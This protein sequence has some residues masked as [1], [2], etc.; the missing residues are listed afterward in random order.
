MTQYDVSVVIPTY[1]RRPL[2]Q[3]AVE[4]VMAQTFSGRIELVVCDD[5]STDDTGSYV[6]ELDAGLDVRYLRN[7]AT[8]G[9]SA[10]RNRGI[11]ESSGS[12]VGLLD[13]DDTWCPTKLE[14]CLEIL[15]ES[16]VDAVVTGLHRVF[17]DGSKETVAI[18]KE[19]VRFP[20]LLAMPVVGGGSSLVV[21]RQLL[22]D[23]GLFDEALPR[24]QD[25]DLLVRLAQRTEI[26]IVPEPLVEKT[27]T[28]LASLQSA[29][30]ARSRFTA[31]HAE[32]IA[33]FSPRDR[34]RIL[35]NHDLHLFRL[36]LA[37]Q[38]YGRAA[39]HALAACRRYPRFALSV[40]KSL[41]IATT[42][43]SRLSTSNPSG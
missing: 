2:L 13:D 21:A 1:N 6:T 41:P 29:E 38:R 18:A 3:R 37:H 20:R 30:I 28:G 19:H 11:R 23:V 33:A 40:W 5:G 36:A 16:G 9:G 4:S 7:S 42:G 8:V 43:G 39:V 10:S 24:Y 17:G 15:K 25:W 22:L 27:A 32:Y 35:G 31:K 14:R 12:Y 34:R 26:G